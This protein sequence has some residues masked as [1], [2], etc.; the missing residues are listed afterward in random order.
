M[1]SSG[2][3][4]PPDPG[5]GAKFREFPSQQGRGSCPDYCSAPATAKWVEV[6]GICA[7]RVRTQE[8]W[9][10]SQLR[11]GTETQRE[12]PRHTGGRS[13]RP[14]VPHMQNV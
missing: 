10:E 14:F 11:W 3:L 5:P 6:D 7:V 13:G 8:L 4:F 2:P 12:A 1:R 9:N